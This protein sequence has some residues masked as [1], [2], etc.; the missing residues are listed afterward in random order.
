MQQQAL[1]AGSGAIFI[2]TDTRV[3]YL[4]PARLD[5]LLSVSVEPTDIG[6]ARLTLRQQCRRGTEVLS[7]GSVEVACVSHGTF[8]P[9]RIP[10]PVLQRLLPLATHATE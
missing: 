2:V 8:R 6:R 4:K 7:E 1:R 9:L 3:R 5:D 10:T